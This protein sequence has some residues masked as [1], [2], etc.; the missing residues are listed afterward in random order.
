M[1]V[2][3]GLFS[4]GQLNDS[5]SLKKKVV[6]YDFV[7]IAGDWVTNSS[8]IGLGFEFGISNGLS[9]EQDL[10]YLFEAEQ[11]A[12]NSSVNV[13]D[14]N[15]IK[16]NSELHFYFNKS[17]STNLI[18]LYW[19]PNLVFQ[20]TNAKHE[21]WLESNTIHYYTVHRYFTALNLK[22]GYQGEIYRN[23]LIDVAVGAGIQNIS[24]NSN[25]KIS[26]G[27]GLS[28]FPFGK[29]YDSGSDWIIGPSFNL[30]IGFRF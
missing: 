11:G 29:Y 15:G 3:P 6:K 24:S 21:E 22:L 17:T 23:L 10:T 27:K 20:Y 9:L 12:S 13:E 28:E 14:L 16:S 25:D 2:L 1:F 5:V 7:S 4:F 19:G 8:G 18:G 26:E 30:R